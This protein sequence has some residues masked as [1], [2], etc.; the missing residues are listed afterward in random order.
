MKPAGAELPRSTE[1]AFLGAIE[2]IYD[3]ATNPAYWPVVLEALARRT[4]SEVASLVLHDVR[5]QSR[6]FLWSFNGDPALLAE[7]ETWAPKNPFIAAVGSQIRTGWIC[8]SEDVLP[9]SQ[10][11][12]TEYFNEYLRRVGV[13]SHIGAC[14]AREGD[15]ASFLFLPRKIG[16]QEPGAKDLSF[17]EALIPHFQRA[18]AIHRRIEGLAIASGAAHEVLDR[19]PFGVLLFDWRGR[20]LLTNRSADD[21]LKPGDGLAL[22]SD[23]RLIATS[24]GAQATLARLI[25]E[26]C[27]TGR[28]KGSAAGGTMLVRRPSG[29]RPFVVLVTPL[30]LLGGAAVAGTPVAAAFVTDPERQSDDPRALLRELYGFTPAESGVA[31]FLFEGRRVSEIAD[32]LSISEETVRSHVKRIL[33]KAE[34]RSQG[35]LIRVLC[36]GPAAF[37]SI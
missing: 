31:W 22:S 32:E 9:S 6:S 17:V 3:A 36:R 18:L 7:D 1:A 27:R 10:A 20:A 24:P 4:Q 33:A 30:R 23:G 11:M 29:L 13:L 26:A 28:G 21:I 16:R 8:N 25:G 35:D 12:R 2:M 15:V 34:C 37:R 5:L 14:I 19:L